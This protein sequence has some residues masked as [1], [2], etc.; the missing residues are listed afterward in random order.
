MYHRRQPPGS[1][2]T[3]Q[4]PVSGFPQGLNRLRPPGI[5]EPD[6]DTGSAGQLTSFS[7]GPI[8]LESKLKGKGSPFST[9]AG[10]HGLLSAC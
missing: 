7:L 1:N 10:T 9:L 2:S 8:W 3:A 5:Q 4:L 6:V